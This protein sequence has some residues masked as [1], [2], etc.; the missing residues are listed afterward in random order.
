[1]V[2]ERVR[3]G[4]EA[5][6]RDGASGAGAGLLASAAVRL[7]TVCGCP[8][9][10]VEQVTC[11]YRFKDSRCTKYYTTG[12]SIEEDGDGEEI[13]AKRKS[14]DKEAGTY[15]VIRGNGVE[16][17]PLLKSEILGMDLW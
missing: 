4:A 16:L 17:L 8:A 7:R 14:M 6:Y 12:K 15:G 3:E 10:F 5:V 2:Q 9:H 13:R 11:I 1:V